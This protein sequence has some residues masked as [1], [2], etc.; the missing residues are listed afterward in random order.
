M[1][2]RSEEWFAARCGSLGASQLNEALATTK[3]G[4]GASRE[5][6]KNR[7]I[8]ERLTGTPTESFTNAAMQWG[9]DQE[10]NARKAYEAHTGTFVDEMGIAFHSVLKHTHASPDGLVGDD[11]LL[12]IKCPN[13][14]THI[15][16]LKSQKVPSKYM[17]QMLWQMRCVDRQ[18]CDYV[19]FDPRLPQHLQLFVKRVERDDVAIAELEA[20]VAEFLTEVEC[21]I[22]ELNRR[23]SDDAE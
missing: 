13:T 22:D 11:G 7:I 12:E 14:T 10:D 1:E 17:N 5:N 6:L 18:W 3:N 20:K 15:E 4:W 23:F 9:V 2:Q 8:A 16:T 19:S 21:E